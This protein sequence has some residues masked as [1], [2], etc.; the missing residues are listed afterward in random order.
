MFSKGCPISHECISTT[1]PCDLV[2]NAKVQE[3]EEVR[4]RS[5]TSFIAPSQGFKTV[6]EIL[7]IKAFD[8]WTLE[9]TLLFFE[10]CHVESTKIFLR[11]NMKGACVC[12]CVCARAC[13]STYLHTFECKQPEVMMLLM[14]QAKAVWKWLD[15]CAHTHTHKR[16]HIKVSWGPKAIAFFS[17]CRALPKLS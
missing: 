15:E 16:G 2:P 7:D 5:G 10:V 14:H 13:A 8:E 12:V 17:F 1:A 6:I 11:S 4:T 9:W 3:R